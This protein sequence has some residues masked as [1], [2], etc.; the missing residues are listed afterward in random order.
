MKKID[1][2]F[3]GYW[4]EKNIGSI[5]KKSGIYV[6]YEGVYV[7]EKA[8]VSLKKIIYIGESTNANERIKGHE[9]WAA[10]ERN[11]QSGRILIFSFAPINGGDRVIGEAALIY[12]HKPPVNEEYKYSFPYENTTMSLSGETA[13]LNTYFTVQNTTNKG[14][15]A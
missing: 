11:C 15:F 3:D 4:R 10:W 14:L 8:T 12:K 5:P 9:K 2:T 6:V 1:V 7:P 13:L